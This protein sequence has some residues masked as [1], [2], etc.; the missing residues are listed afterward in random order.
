LRK[1]LVLAGLSFQKQLEV[2][3]D[4]L[5]ER[6]RSLSVMISLYFLWSA[7]L[8]HQ[9]GLLGYD[10][11]HLLTYVLMATL[12]RAIV[13]SCA[14]DYLP[15]EIA[16]GKLSDVLLRPISHMGYWAAQDASSKLLSLIAASLE[17]AIFMKLVSAPFFVPR[18]L[19]TWLGFSF[20]LLGGM[21]IYFQMSYLLGVLGFWTAQSWGP[22]FCFEVV[23]EFCGG[24][25]FP[26]DLLPAGWQRV[27]YVLPFPYLVFFPLKI[28][29][30]RGSFM[31]IVHCLLMLMFWI[32]A[33]SLMIH[34]FWK[35][36]LKKYAAEGR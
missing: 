5:F 24:A 12:L 32:A 3:S 33:L 34:T 26:I 4:F 31:M 7:L 35:A 18:D 9:D 14:S 25:Y 23:L 36:G 27:L 21:T 19:V 8:V 22:R 10:R 28:Y 17:L 29:L 2:R 16:K 15:S 13:L 20:S 6:V 11:Q 30:E 1:Y